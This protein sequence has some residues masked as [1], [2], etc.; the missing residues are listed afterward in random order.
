MEELQ[1]TFNEDTLDELFEGGIEYVIYN[2]D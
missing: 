2:E 1:N